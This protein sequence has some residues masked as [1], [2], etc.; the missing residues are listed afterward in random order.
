MEIIINN[1]NVNFEIMDDIYTIKNFLLF[2]SYIS[3][4][5][6]YIGGLCII[7]Y[8]IYKKY[9]TEFTK[10]NTISIIKKE[11]IHD[12]LDNLEKDDNDFF[13]RL[14]FIIRSYLEDSER[15]PFATKK[16][17]NNIC[18]DSDVREFQNILTECMHIIYAGKSRDKNIKQEMI[19][20]VRKI[21]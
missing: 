15:V 20:R 11:S 8:M 19:Q 1:N 9:I 2:I 13:E 14:S 5:T 18:G 21:I 4:E 10:Y 6:W 3:S 12:A 16:T 17:P 7:L